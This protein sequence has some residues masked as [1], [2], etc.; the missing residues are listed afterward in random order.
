MSYGSIGRFNSV[1]ILLVVDRGTPTL[2]IF[3]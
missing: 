1:N 3:V 2:A